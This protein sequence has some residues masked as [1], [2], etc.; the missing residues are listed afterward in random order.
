MCTELSLNTNLDFNLADQ[1][2]R[3]QKKPILNLKYLKLRLKL[4]DK[5]KISMM[6]FEDK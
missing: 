4:G 6:T 5:G 2:P 1:Y 3:S